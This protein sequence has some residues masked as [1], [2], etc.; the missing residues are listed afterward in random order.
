MF[1]SG[2]KVNT[3]QFNSMRRALKPEASIA[4]SGSEIQAQSTIAK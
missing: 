1:M 2:T 4:V 3:I